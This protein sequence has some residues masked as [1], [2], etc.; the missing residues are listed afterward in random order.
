MKLDLGVPCETSGFYSE[1]DG[2]HRMLS[3]EVT[4][5]GICFKRIRINQSESR[6]T[7]L[8]T[9][10]VILERN[11][12]DLGQ[13]GDSGAGLKS[14]LNLDMFWRWSWQY[15]LADHIWVWKKNQGWFRSVSLSSGK[16]R[17]A[18]Y[19]SGEYYE[20][21]G[22]G[23]GCTDCGIRNLVLDIG[24][25]LLLTRFLPKVTCPLFF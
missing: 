3:R 10:T 15:L 16:D 9:V 6:E 12:S 11:G 5:S 19:W 17:I 18:I 24:L 7:S 20:K 25:R 13:S 8:E 14:D 2:G 4:W 23:G 22:L 1:W 21:N